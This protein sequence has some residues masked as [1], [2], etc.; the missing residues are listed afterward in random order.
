MVNQA[1]LEKI[2]KLKAKAE[3]PSVTE[4]EALMY[5]GKV[6]EMLQELNLSEAALDVEEG[7]ST[8]EEGLYNSRTHMPWS[9][10]VATGVA[11]L[12][13]CD[14]FINYGPG[15]RVRIIFV[16]RAHNVE[17]ARSMSDYL[18]KTVVRLSNTYAKA[19][20]G[21]PGPGFNKARNG[22]ERGAG[23]RLYKRLREKLAEQTQAPPA[24]SAAGNPANLTALYEDEG[25]LVSAY[26]KAKG[27]LKGRKQNWNYDKHAH[28]GGAAANGI[29]LN[30][31]V[32]TKGT[33]LLGKK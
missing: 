6:A 7:P 10:T 31:Q 27:L 29:S 12:Y 2:R 21:G 17:I 8:S 4:A 22:F 14:I 16:G 11:N 28:A 19:Q 3:D 33:N 32:G 30:A 1:K 20:T 9:R 15:P 26:L 5:A 23:L 13:F 18:I 24:R 25:K